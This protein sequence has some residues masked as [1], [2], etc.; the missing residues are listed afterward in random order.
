V[1]RLRSIT[2]AGKLA[3]QSRQENDEAGR[4]RPRFP[5]QRSSPSCNEIC[6][7]S[8]L[9][10]VGCGRWGSYVLSKD[11]RPGSHD[12]ASHMFLFVCTLVATVFSQLSVGFFCFRA[13][14]PRTNRARPSDF[15]RAQ[16]APQNARRS[17]RPR[18]AARCRTCS[19]R[20]CGSN[21]GGSFSAVISLFSCSC[22]SCSSRS[23][24]P[25]IDIPTLQVGGF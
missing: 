19:R 13:A 6:S 21:T 1:L 8:A 20:P 11:R 7:Q 24:S 4:K 23:G 3:S 25:R 14:P 18:S 12:G 5:R 22:R 10:A 2:A 9:T 16:P 15:D 17:A